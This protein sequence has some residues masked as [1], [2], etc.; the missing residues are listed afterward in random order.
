MNSSGRFERTV[1]VHL[2]A[3]YNF[4]RWLTRDDAGAQDAVQEACLRALRFFESQRGE[5]PKAWFMTIVRNASLDW[6]K[7]N[8]SRALEEQYDDD[9]HTSADAGDETPHAAAARASDAR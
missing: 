2:D 8:R 7:A 5:S 6:L 1:L 3:A 9:I 4:A